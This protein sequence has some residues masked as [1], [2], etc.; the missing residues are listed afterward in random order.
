MRHRLR[1]LATGLALCGG[2]ILLVAC[3]TGADK[4]VAETA[5]ARFHDGFNAGNYHAI[6]VDT[7]AEFRGA[8]S[9]AD[10]AALLASVMAKAG[11]YESSR[12]TSWLVNNGTEGTVVTLTYEAVLSRAIA[13]ENFSWRVES[14]KA[15]LLG[16]RIEVQSEVGR[17]STFRVWLGPA[18]KR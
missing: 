11:R 3:S 16:Y 12:Q 6:Y 13:V 17:G 9:E 18:S 15:V 14:G 4:A 8:T 1:H 10:F 2:A 7:S 5:V